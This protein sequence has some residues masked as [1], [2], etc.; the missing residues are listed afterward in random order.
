[1]DY[2][3]D[4]SG[5]TLRDFLARKDVRLSESELMQCY[6]DWMAASSESWYTD[7]R[8]L[9][10]NGDGVKDL[11]LSGNGEYFWQAVTFRHGRIVSLVEDSFYLC[12]NGVLELISTRWE[13]GIEMDGHQY[14]RI[15]E[16]GRDI[17]ELVVYNKAS[18]SW[19]SDWYASEMT[20]SQAQTI[21]DRYPRL[22]Q[23]MMPIEEFLNE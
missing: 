6:R 15:T 5:M 2:P 7:F 17:L 11:L 10:I 1:M 13:G 3:L 23:D 22:D 14:M 9:D 12:E 20:Q 21:L 19:Q 8:L 16:S 4:E 18:A